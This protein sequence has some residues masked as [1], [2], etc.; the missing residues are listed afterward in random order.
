MSAWYFFVT[1]AYREEKAFAIKTAWATSIFV[2][3]DDLMKF[4]LQHERCESLFLLKLLF[5][6]W[7]PAQ[8]DTVM[9]CNLEQQSC[10]GWGW[11]CSKHSSKHDGTIIHFV[12][13]TAEI[14]IRQ[15]SHGWTWILERWIHV[16]EKIKAFKVDGDSCGLPIMWEVFLSETVKYVFD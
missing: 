8:G 2:S 11:K 16:D 12:R 1:V 13:E 5:N 7:M 6:C 9:E 14:A 10:H 4:V 3:E 15:K